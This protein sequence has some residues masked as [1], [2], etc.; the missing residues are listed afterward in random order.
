MLNSWSSSPILLNCVFIGNSADQGDGGGMYIGHDTSAIVT[1]CTFSKNSG[2]LGGGLY[3]DYYHTVTDVKNTILWGNYRIRSTSTPSEI[4]IGTLSYATLNLT[5]SCIRNGFLYAGA[6]CISNDPRFRDANGAYDTYGTE[7]DAF[8]LQSGSPCINKGTKSGAPVIDILG[9]ARRNTP[10]MG[11]YES[12]N[13]G[14]PWLFL[15]LSD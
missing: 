8:L 2:Y 10:D 1:N 11:A 12:L 14:M 4:Y 15:L 13:T 9:V 6:G 3:I 7:E 5:Y